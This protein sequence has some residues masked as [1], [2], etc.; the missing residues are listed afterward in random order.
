MCESEP[1]FLLLLLVVLFLFFLVV[2][3]LSEEKLKK[4]KPTKKLRLNWL[5]IFKGNT[6]T[7]KGDE[8]SDAHSLFLLIY[9]RLIFSSILGTVNTHVLNISPSFDNFCTT[10]QKVNREHLLW[11][12]AHRVRLRKKFTQML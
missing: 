9:F 8:R 4:K 1:N 11:M 5:V 3:A 6:F 2:C 10:K 7:C 12:V